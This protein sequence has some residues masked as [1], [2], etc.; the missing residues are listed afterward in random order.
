MT[1]RD[2]LTGGDRRSIARASEALDIA[3]QDQAAVDELARL[4]AGPDPLVAERAL[5]VLEKLVHERP[6]WLQP[7]RQVFVDLL[8][9]PHWECRLQCVRAIPAL[10]WTQQERSAVVERLREAIDD[11]QKFV[12]CWALDGYARLADNDPIK[13]KEIDRRLTE[14]LGSGVPSMR[15]RARAIAKRLAPYTQE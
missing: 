4:T 2:L 8:A 11:S 6:E 5:D 3:R 13:R 7:H 10:T 12:S 15:A 9:H 1:L 14:F